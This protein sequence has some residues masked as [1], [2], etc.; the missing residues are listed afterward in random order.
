[1]VD[2][3]QLLK[4]CRRAAQAGCRVV[5]DWQGKARVWDKRPAD[6][7]TQADLA[8]QLEIESIVLGEYPEHDFLGE[9]SGKSGIDLSPGKICWIVDPIDGTTNY[10]HGLPGYAVS[11]AV[12]EG[13][14][15]LAGNVLDAM[16]C[17]D[18][19]AVRDG[20]AFLGETKLAGSQVTS[21]ERAL[22]AVS[23]PPRVDRDSLELRRLIEVLM[24]AQAIRRLGSAAL[25]L[26]YVAAGRLDAYFAT[27]VK[28]WDIAAGVLL[29]EEAGGVVWNIDGGPFSLARPLLVAAAN[30][31]LARELV[32]TL[33]KA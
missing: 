32:E 13:E 23:L 29:V 12:A 18:F 3:A 20:G 5:R 27:A 22:V 7:V 31:Q 19:W 24:A 10:V 30:A 25:N 6:L 33:Q 11:V 9:E 1:M 8:S 21:L 17:E 4:V 28:P 2:T 15:V 26:A 16:S 14:Q